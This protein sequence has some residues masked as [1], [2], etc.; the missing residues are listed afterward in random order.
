MLSQAGCVR[1]QRSEER[2]KRKRDLDAAE[3]AKRLREE[4]ESEDLVSGVACQTDESMT[5]LEAQAKSLEKQV[6]ELRAEL[7]GKTTKQ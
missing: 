7:D 6:Q 5:D 2:R 3:V 4:G 1:Y